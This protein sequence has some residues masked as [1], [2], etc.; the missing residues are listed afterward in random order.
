MFSKNDIEDLKNKLEK[1]VGRTITFRYNYTKSKRIEKIKECEG[2]IEGISSNVL[3]LRKSI[4]E[5]ISIIE[6][7]TFIDILSGIIEIIDIK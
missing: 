1:L 6:S 3:V 5:N 2:S 7:Y 4:N